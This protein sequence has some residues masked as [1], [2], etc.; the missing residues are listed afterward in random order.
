MGQRVQIDSRD[1]DLKRP[2][3]KLAEKTIGP[4]PISEIVSPNAIRVKFP[5][6]IKIHLVIN[7]S[8]VHENKEPTIPGQA[9]S[10]PP[11]VEIGN[12]LEYEVEEVLD[13]RLFWNKLQYLIKWKGYTEENNTWE[14]VT[15][16]DNVKDAIK[17]FHQTHPSAPR[18]LRSL[19][20]L[21]YF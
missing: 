15:N 8:R 16:L 12:E 4:F 21:K 18:Q 13:S 3:K 7:V 10:E 9:V 1:L 11:P 17:E 6:S 14:P 20:L 2:S 19:D 5:T